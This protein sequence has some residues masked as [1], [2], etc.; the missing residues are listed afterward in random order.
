[1][2][3][4]I[5]RFASEGVL[6]LEDVIDAADAAEL[7][8]LSEALLCAGVRRRPGVRRALEREPRLAMALHRSRVR[9]LLRALCGTGVSCVR[10]IVFDKSPGM[11]WSVPWH[12]DATIA[13]RARH[14][15]SGYGPWSVKDD[16]THVQPPREILDALVV[17]RLALDDCPIEAGPLQ[18][19]L[20]SHVSGILSAEQMQALVECG[21]IVACT[22]RRGG[23]AVMRPHTVHSSARS[24]GW[25]HARRV[26]HLECTSVQLPA[27]LEWAERVDVDPQRA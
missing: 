23:A 22:M 2:S 26:L 10:A 24:N 27:P 6:V 13:V 3:D 15:V 11:N 12:Q 20:G 18:V 1:M 7:A 9:D 21:P 8:Q 16:E 19:V 5:E 14:D 17:L 4:R 25:A